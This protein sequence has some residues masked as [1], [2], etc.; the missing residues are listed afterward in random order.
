LEDREVHA[1]IAEDARDDGWHEL[2]VLLERLL[3]FSVFVMHNP[4][5]CWL[6]IPS[7]SLL[8]FWICCSDWI[9]TVAARG[10][11]RQVDAGFVNEFQLFHVKVLR[12]YGLPLVE[13]A[14]LYAESDAAI[15]K[16]HAA[17]C[18]AAKA[19]DFVAQNVAKFHSHFP[20]FVSA[21]MPAKSE[22][23]VVDSQS[24]YN[25]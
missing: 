7:V 3:R 24:T 8:A 2:G 17:G 15:Q 18:H 20:L 14:R 22:N 4:A 11:D 25:P 6:H 9:W 19:R 23:R 10:L 16:L 21:K 5:D 1:G 13:R 12:F